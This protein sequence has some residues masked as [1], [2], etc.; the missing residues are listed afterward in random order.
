VQWSIVPNPSPGSYIN[1]LTGVAALSSDDV[2][3]VGYYQS[4]DP[5]QT[6][7]EH[8]DGGQWSVINTPQIPQAGDTLLRKVKAIAT[9]DVW[10]VGVYYG[11]EGYARTLVEHWDGV[12]WSIVP[13]PILS[14]RPNA[15]MDLAV[16]GP[17][18]I[19]AVGYYNDD[20]DIQYTLIEHWDGVQWS[21]VP[22]SSAANPV[23]MG[24]GGSGPNDVWAVGMDFNGTLI[25]HWDGGQWSIVPAPNP[26]SQWDELLSVKAFSPTDAWAVGYYVGPNPPGHTF[27]VHWD[28]IAWTLVPSPSPG[29]LENVLSNVE[30]LSSND[31][32]AVGWYD[33]PGGPTRTLVEHYTGPC[34]TSTPT[35]TPVV[36]T[37]TP[38]LTAMPTLPPTFTATPL[39]TSTSTAT[40]Q[41]IAT[42]T[43]C[44]IAFTDVPEGSTFYPYIHCLACLGILNGYDTGC[45]TGNPCFRPGNDVSRGQ[46]SKIVANASSFQEAHT[47]QT[48]ADVPVGSTFYQFVE[49]MASR[50]IIGGYACGGVGEPCDSQHRPYF[51]PQSNATRGQI[52]KI[53]VLAA[54][55]AL[56]W[57]LSNP[58][59]NT[60]E[61]VGVG[62]TFYQYI[63]AAYAHN[64]LGGYPCGGAGEPC[65]PGNKPYF[66][67]NNNASRGQTS[68]I[69][70]STFFPDCNP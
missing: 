28:G 43:A 69:V 42:P 7:A 15:L 3:A 33:Y 62:S 48:F 54:V 59:T 57:T 20:N 6:L 35:S 5:Y 46:L 34:D 52:A 60:F 23:L 55:Q 2:W 49:R 65:G 17:Q 56:G 1:Y 19:W 53:D 16:I 70:S 8:W 29:G 12:Q 4:N 11:M 39:T 22:S 50:S 37:S 30:V 66:R 25:E 36:N 24:V 38:T 9:N 14:T 32:W 31:V 26:G 63:E 58:A 67:P 45:E 18:D 13:T 44:A 47:E 40:S 61:D 68:K 41:P 10:T 51:R 21:V 64:V 27:T